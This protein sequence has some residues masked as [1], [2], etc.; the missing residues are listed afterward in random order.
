MSS[1]I[2]EK[3]AQAVGILDAL[4]VDAWLTNRNDIYYTAGNRARPIGLN[5]APV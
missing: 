1:I 3:I 2:E 4:Q 5:V